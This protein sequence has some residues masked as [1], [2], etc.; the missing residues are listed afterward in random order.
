MRP[1][2]IVI[3]LIIGAAP[4]LARP[5]LARAA[6]AACHMDHGAVVVTASLGNITGDFILDLSAPQSQLHQTRAES[7][8]VTTP[9]LTAPLRIA[10]RR[11]DA[12]RFVVADLDARDWGYATEISGVIGA[13]ALA[14]YGLDLRQTPCRIALWRRPPGGFRPVRRLR[15]GSQAAPAVRAWVGDGD[16]SRWG[17]FGLDTGSAGVRLS[18]REAALSRSPPN[19]DAASHLHPPA[20]LRSLTMGKMTFTDL[21]AGLDPDAPPDRLGEIGNA[22]WGRYAL[23]LDPE[24]RWLELAPPSP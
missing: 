18:G 8:G 14:G 23:R 20:R 17:W 21:P 1:A 15:L 5:E 19:L 4:G 6:E 16:I 9:D 24:R 12:A 2:K 10:G 13:D 3:A 11:L 7:E 22:V